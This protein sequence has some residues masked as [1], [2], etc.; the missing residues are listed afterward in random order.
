ML[1]PLRACYEAPSCAP[2]TMAEFATSR[3]KRRT[4]ESGGW[5]QALCLTRAAHALLLIPTFPPA[6]TPGPR[7]L[8]VMLSF[9][10]CPRVRLNSGSRNRSVE[11]RLRG[12]QTAGVPA[13]S[14]GLGSR[15]GEENHSSRGPEW[16]SGMCAAP[17]PSGSSDRATAWGRPACGLFLLS[18]Q[19][20]D[21]VL[22]EGSPRN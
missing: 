12:G 5:E 13:A 9:H 20:Q 11:V 4:W 10:S 19:A 15:P 8:I 3:L 16:D 22:Q 7:T 21:T 17:S 1:W 2:V 6:L 14:Q 18:W